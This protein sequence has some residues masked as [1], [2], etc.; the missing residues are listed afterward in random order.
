METLHISR[1][2]RYAMTYRP[3][4]PPSPQERELRR[5]EAVA[6]LVEVNE[7]IQKLKSKKTA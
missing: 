1:L 2:L 7:V 6:E 5:C 4:P 3:L